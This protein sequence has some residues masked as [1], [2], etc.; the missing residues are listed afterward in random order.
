MYTLYCCTFV[1]V[2][3]WPAT[4]WEA[5]GGPTGRVKWLVFYNSKGK[6]VDACYSVSY[7][8]TNVRI[9]GVWHAL[10]RDFAVILV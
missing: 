8:E 4:M 10:S 1:F 3:S 9:S 6:G 7:W 5:A 2:V